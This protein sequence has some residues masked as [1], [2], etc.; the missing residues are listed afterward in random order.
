M[1]LVMLLIVVED[2]VIFK[3]LK[4]TIEPK[5]INREGPLHK[6]QYSTEIRSLKYHC[7][8]ILWTTQSSQDKDS[9]KNR[10]S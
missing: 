2:L 1:W 9:L 5:N 8:T 7:L 3:N 6:M 4:K 10:Q